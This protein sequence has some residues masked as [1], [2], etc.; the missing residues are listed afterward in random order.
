MLKRLMIAADK[1]GSGKTTITCALLAAMKKRNL[2]IVSFKCGPDYID[3]LFHEKIIGIP[4]RNLDMFF[5]G[6]SGIKKE[7]LKEERSGHKYALIEAAMGLF[8]GLGGISSEC[9]AY[10]TAKVTKTP[11]VLLL[12]ARGCGR[13]IISV[14]KGILA[15]DTEHL[16]RGVV[17]NKVSK[18]FYELIK[19]V[20]EAETKLEC[21]G[22]FPICDDAVFDS[23]H[24]G[25]KLPGEIINYEERIEHLSDIALNTIN[26]DRL[27]EIMSD[28]LDFNADE[29]THSYYIA[30]KKLK[31]GVA[32]DD[33]FC[34]YYKSN[35]EEFTKRNVEIVFFSPL[36][37][38]ALPEGIN[39]LYFGGGYPELRLA[40]LEKN[41]SMREAIRMAISND[42]P[43]IAECG[44]F[45]YLH[46][47]IA[48][49]EIEY[50]MVGAINGKCINTGKLNR[51]GYIDLYLKGEIIKGHEF[52]Y[53]DSDNTGAEAKAIKPVSG[54]SWN[55][56]FVADN[57]I[58]GFPHMYFAS[59]CRIIDRFV[60][61][62][63]DYSY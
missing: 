38:R 2:D 20:I 46:E 41:S 12:D 62:M 27:V 25:L 35:L 3:P 54:R 33:A 1:S 23:R 36:S 15:D 26:V 50:K 11:V 45:M 37:D 19:P 24:L 34:F 29:E 51:F 58:W 17:L 6:E 16:I 14:I 40:E 63:E 31:L 56:S 60:R 55:C 61:A 59:N 28:A 48:D 21:L 30:S 49:K 44:G 10:D 53:Y 4:S 43:S 13:T 57:H 5:A 42:L 52:H 8:D 7:I 39:G 9:S 32:L 47:S 22:Y 18:G